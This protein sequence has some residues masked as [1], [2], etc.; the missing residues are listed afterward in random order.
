M[1]VI[2]DTSSLLAL[3]RYYL[4]FDTSGTLKEFIKEKFENGELLIIDKVFEEASYISKGIIMSELDFLKDKKKHI[5]TTDILPN[6]AFFNLLENQFCNKDVKRLQDITDVEFEFE[7]E[8]YLNMADA[9]MILYALSIRK[10]N[11]ILVTEETK[12]A[13]DNKLFKKLPD[14]CHT[15]NIACCNL[16]YLFKEH[17][18]VNISDYLK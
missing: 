4:P 14:N 5:K 9:K 7:K 18:G 17:F 11:P 3:V 16:P 10:E 12:N 2:I 15:I 8:R 6:S 1:N 13:N